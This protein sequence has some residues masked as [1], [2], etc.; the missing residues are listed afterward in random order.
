MAQFSSLPNESLGSF[1]CAKISASTWI[2]IIFIFQ[3]YFIVQC[4]PVGLVNISVN[5]ENLHMASHSYDM[6]ITW[7]SC[8]EVVRDGGGFTDKATKQVTA[9]NFSTLVSVKPET[10]V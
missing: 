3:I 1:C 8:C 10:L 6:F 9:V 2:R 4:S 5:A 7:L